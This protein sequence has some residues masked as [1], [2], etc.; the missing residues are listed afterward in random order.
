MHT[1]IEPYITYLFI[2][3]QYEKYTS[4]AEVIVSDKDL[5]RYNKPPKFR[6][7]AHWNSP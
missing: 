3:L 5:K 2:N 4:I 7:C 6:F 1:L